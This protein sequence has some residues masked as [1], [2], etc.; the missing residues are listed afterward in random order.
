MNNQVR[1]H[2]FN[3]ATNILT[4]AKKKSEGFDHIFKQ[5]ESKT[6]NEAPF[7]R[8]HLL[9]DHLNSSCLID[10]SYALAWRRPNPHKV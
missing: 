2:T 1:L 5:N 6:V 10:G 9:A 7:Y 4:N 8:P 3:M